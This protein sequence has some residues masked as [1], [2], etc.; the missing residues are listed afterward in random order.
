MKNL[1]KI[2]LAIWFVIVLIFNVVVFATYGDVGEFYKY[3]TSF[4]VRL[5]FVNLSFVLQLLFTKYMIENTENTHK[6]PLAEFNVSLENSGFLILQMLAAVIIALFPVIPTIL[7]PISAFVVLLAN[8][9]VLTLSNKKFKSFFNDLF[10]FLNKRVIKFVII[11][12]T[13]FALAVIII[14]PTVIYP[15]IKYKNGMEYIEQDNLLKACSELSKANGYKDSAKQLDDI[16]SKDKTLSIYKANIG[17]TV[18]FGKY[19]QDANTDNGYEPLEWTVLDKKGN[20]VLLITSYCIDKVPYHNAL[21]DITWEKCSLREWLNTKF[22]ELAFNDTEKSMLHKTYLSNNKNPIYI[23]PKPGKST[24]DK[25][26]I[27]SYYEA[28]YYLYS[29]ELINVYTT[30]TAQ[31]LL[32]SMDAKPS[33]GWWWL[34]TPGA[35]NTSAMTNHE[36][37][38]F[39]AMGYQVNHEAYTIRPCIWVEL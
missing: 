16:I 1:F 5:L 14:I 35:A 39:S 37:K 17:D 21:V 38:Q 27:L 25:V 15:S 31:S 12:C 10:N 32:S 11:P 28:K 29:D 34:R 20:K 7:I 36:Q 22:I 19:E 8:F 30:K 23:A 4:F 6:N 2:Y 13:V 18:K 9:L 24:Y 33:I 26:F 3:D